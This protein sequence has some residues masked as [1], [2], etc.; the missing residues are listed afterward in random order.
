MTMGTSKSSI[1][2]SGPDKPVPDFTSMIA[3][4]LE[5]LDLATVLRVSQAVSGEMVL[6]RL[7]DTLMRTA[8]EHAGAERALLI[9]A[10]EAGPRITAEARTSNDTTVVRL[11]DEPVTGSL[12]PEAVLRYVLRTRQNVLLDDAAAPNPLSTEPYIARHRARSVFCLTLSNHAKLIGVLYLESNLAPGVFAP[13]RTAVLKLLVSQAAISIE[14]ARLHAELQRSEERY[15]LAVEAAGDGYTDWIVATDE[16]YASSRLLRMLGLPQDARFSGHADFLARQPIHP[17]DRDRVAQI[18]QQ[19]YAGNTARLEFGLRILRRGEVRWLH[20]T[21][22]CLRDPWGGLLRVSSAVTD[23]T[24][25]REAE[26][27]LRRSEARKGAVLDTA[28]DCIIA[29]DENGRIVDF[30]P[31]AERTFGVLRS[32]TLGRDVADLILPA[33]LRE[34]HRL[35]LARFLET[36]E[37]TRLGRRRELA[38]LRA[39]GTEFPIELAIAATRVG[40]DWLFSA[41][42]RDITERRS[43]EEELRESEQQYRTLFDSIDEG[44]CTIEVLF[45]ENVKP[46]DYR[47]LQINPSFERQTGIKNAVGRRMREIA[48]QHEEHWFETYGKIALTGEPL[49]FENEAKQLGRWYDLYAFRLE[50]PKIRCV[51]ILFN[52][53]TE[54]KRVEE[55]LR[56]RQEMLDLAQK[57]ARAVA[58]EWRRGARA[59]TSGWPVSWTVR[60]SAELEGIFG[61]APGSFDGSYESWKKLVHPEDWAAV[62]SSLAI[63]G[64]TGDMSSEYR[65]VISGS[66]PRWVQSKGRML[67]DSQGEPERL[68]GFVL[69]VTEKHTAEDEL[70]RLEKQLRQ[71]QRLEALGTL[72][73][74]IAHDFNNILGAILGFSEMAARD[75]PKGSRLGR[76]VDAIIV[77]G[78]RGRAL[79]DKIIA[80]SS[81]RSTGERVAVHVER[82]V[83]E[84]MALVAAKLP[85]GVRIDAKLSAGLAATRGDPTQVHQ[86]L[87]NLATNAVHAMQ[88]GGTLRVALELLRVDTPRLGTV[89]TLEPGEYIALTVRDTG[90]GMSPE[91]LE[92]MFDPFFTTKETGTGTGLGLSLVH[93]I[94]ADMNG[95]IDVTSKLGAGTEFI[96]YLPRTGDAADSAEEDSEPVVPGGAG[97]RVLVVDDEEPL[98]RL[99]ARTLEE[100][101]YAPSGF[102]SS[103][104]A[105]E[106]FRSEPAG[107]DAVITDERMPGMSGTALIR[108]MRG[109]R[110]DIPVLLMSGFV[111]GAVA[112]AARKAGADEVLKK[113]LLARDLA[114]S[115]A[116]I[117]QRR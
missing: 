52:D 65:V 24:E 64:K 91:V 16:F 88:S 53:I 73:A 57:A 11:C 77:A 58:F 115:L 112:S 72:A 14:N 59:A 48:P 108:E 44:F 69:D 50:D 84:A 101:G 39:D 18:V 98:M 66:A 21:Q 85:E 68:V 54:R 100:L 1:Q 103:A 62:K 81:S 3:A 78:E 55:E 113:P 61:V 32:E 41:Y 89:G 76:D 9:L 83:R 75:A 79:I 19:H 33:R 40:G 60:V 38:A 90:T 12:L 67:F 34:A 7:L 80:F 17:E 87:L 20:T 82:V 2:S 13:A 36:R 97:E 104:A 94:V 46:V 27:A 42:L 105:L 49:R 35:E 26:E 86:V 23:V 25:A 70:R 116:R 93:G 47:F 74:G 43:I 15:A 30:N 71:A 22:L 4:P 106:A 37:A 8:V 51:G 45:D 96:V 102:T 109:I 99:A 114:T 5:H 111:G 95:A 117:L 63:A 110:G 92:R 107:F 31:A 10:R 29:M 56:A 28:L 6:E